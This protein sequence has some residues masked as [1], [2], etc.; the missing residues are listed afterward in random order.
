M[1]KVMKKGLEH[2]PVEFER[3][4]RM[5]DAGSAAADKLDDF[6]YRVNILGVFLDKADVDDE[7]G[8]DAPEEGH[9]EL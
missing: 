4:T 6:A 3:L 5:I 8:V 2:I 1:K 9:E 7:E